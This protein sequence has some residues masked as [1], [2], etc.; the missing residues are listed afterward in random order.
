MR[1]L[2]VTVAALLALS[3][4]A[5]AQFISTGERGRPRPFFRLP[6]AS[7]ALSRNLSDKLADAV[8]VRDFGARCDGKTD[9]TR[10]LNAAFKAA[11]GLALGGQAV[12]INGPDFCVT[13]PITISSTTSNV[14]S[15]IIGYGG[16]LRARAASASPT[17]TIET[18]EN[19]VS[20]FV[21]AGLRIQANAL[22]AQGLKIHGS[23]HAIYRDMHISAA[24]AGAMWLSGEP[25]FGIYA[26]EFGNLRLDTST[27]AGLIA[28]SINNVGQYY[29]AANDF[30]NV[31][32]INNTTYGLDADYAS[33]SFVNSLF[34][35][36]STCGVNVDHSIQL[37]LH[38]AH[39]EGNN[40]TACVL[41]GTANTTGLKI[42]GGRTIGTITASVANDPTTLIATTDTNAKALFYVGTTKSYASGVFTAGEVNMASITSTLALSANV[43]Y[44]YPLMLNG[45]ATWTTIAFNVTATGTA[46]SCKPGLFTSGT[47]ALPGTLI[48]DGGS[49]AVGSTG[50]KTASISQALGPALYYGVIVCDGT[51]TLTSATIS[52][53]SPG[54]RWVEMVGITAFGTAD[55]QFSKAFTFG[56]LSGATPFGAVTRAAA[57]VPLIALKK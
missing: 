18:P 29:I 57:N 16:G 23:Q 38:S 27:G 47:D 13:D 45:S 33:L 53:L 15:A 34:E 36:N 31:E 49:V 56:V 51:V 17:L 40:G 22:H 37:D 35:G 24:T 44:A 52:N 7:A 8:N 46:V 14:P 42:V 4:V 11:G 39:F 6:N 12:I 32:S 41:T 1:R 20:K 19:S 48:V 3:S 28:K 25:S 55:T 5:D 30:H 10:A 21:L 50:T 26:N 2:L 43:L 54:G 9:D